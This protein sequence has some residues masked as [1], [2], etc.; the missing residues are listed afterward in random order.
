[1]PNSSTLVP[2]STVALAIKYFIEGI[3]V[4]YPGI[5][6]VYDDQLS[7]ESAIAKLRAKNS[8][9][10]NTPSSNVF[11]LFVF[12]RSQLKFDDLTLNKRGAIFKVKN[13][14]GKVFRSTWSRVDLDFLF[15]SSNFNH[16]ETFEI[17]YNSDSGFRN[18]VDF[19]VA[20]PDLGNFHYFPRWI[21]DLEELNIDVQNIYYKALSS[22]VQIPGWYLLLYG[23]YKRI[24]E[25]NLEI[26]T[27][28]E[29]TL[30]NIVLFS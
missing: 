19:Q 29:E 17:N 30:Q 9:E 26:K 5:N 15:V 12:R 10:E 23:D 24:E 25:I 28:E 3:K 13:S 2:V 16:I 1:M 14:N 21:N 8:M 27:F 20:F 6:Y 18:F 22:K 4:R 7:V 11:P